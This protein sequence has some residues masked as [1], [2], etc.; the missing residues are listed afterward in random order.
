MDA[1][2]TL[3]VKVDLPTFGTPTI[4]TRTVFFTP[5]AAIFSTASLAACSMRRM[6]SL[7]R[8]FALSK[9]MQSSPCARK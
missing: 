6:T 9:L 3:L 8:P 5:R 2:F 1:P 4:I 7:A